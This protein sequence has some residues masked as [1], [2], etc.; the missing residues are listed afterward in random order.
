MHPLLG[1][2]ARPTVL[3]LLLA[4]AAAGCGGRESLF[5]GMYGDGVSEPAGG[6]SH[7]GGSSGTHSSTGGSSGLGAGGSLS[8]G[9]GF[10]TGGVGGTGGTGG[11]FGTGGN[12]GSGGTGGTF[13]SGGFGTSGFGNGGSSG[14]GTAGFGMAGSAGSSF[15][16]NGGSSAM[17]GDPCA[18]NGALACHGAA[19]RLRL[20]CDGGVWRTN[21]TC[22]ASENCDQRS[23]VCAPIVTGCVGLT[24]GQRY[25]TNDELDQCGPDLVTSDFVA[26]CSGR[27]TATSSSASCAPESCGDGKVEAGEACDDGDGNDNNACTNR[28]TTAVCGDGSLYL[29]REACDDGNTLSGDSC[30]VVCG[31]DAVQVATGYYHTCALGKSGN[32]QCWGNNASGQ[33][34]VGDTATRG[35]YSGDMGTNLP[36]VLLGSGK[37][38][39]AVSVAGQTSCALLNDATVKCWG[40][41]SYGALGVGDTAA[42]GTAKNQLGDN[43]PPV[44]LGSGRTALKVLTGGYHTCALLDDHSV[45]CWGFNAYGQLGQGDSNNRGDVQYELGDALPAIAL[46]SG[47]SALTIAVGLMHSCA[48]LDDHSVKCWGYGG[49]GQLGLGDT[50]YRGISPGQMGDALPPVDLGSGR[51]ATAIAA[52]DYHTCALLDDATVKCWGYNGY[53]QL[54][55]G[56][57]NQRGYVMGQ[58]GDALAPVSLGTGHTAKAVS[59]GTYSSCAVLEN[60]QVKCWGYNQ[61]GGLG[62]GDTATRGDN[63]NELGNFLP[64]A[65]LGSGRSVKQVTTGLYHTCAVLDNGT[66]KCWGGNNYG[67]LGLGVAS[68]AS[69]GDAAGEMGDYLPYVVVTF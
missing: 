33:L 66:I 16:G 7:R 49:Y 6:T 8:M 13:N 68:N 42:R 14:F 11:D 41:N 64:S 3:I 2:S 32:I 39:S 25:C 44:P 35:Y 40:V 15:A 23:G 28:C 37:T 34:G 18:V 59:A 10:G 26:A 55:Q 63:G 69:V 51:T 45:K 27:C 48:L 47:R 50:N 12:G 61:Q 5:G 43:L 17:L 29:G 30:S 24:P 53:G 57:S 38:A 9:G 19:Q 67:Q 1:R 62:I 52:G 22:V 21:G 58:M 60:D 31:S 56:D 20:L 54:G 46:G 4:G 65:S 36:A